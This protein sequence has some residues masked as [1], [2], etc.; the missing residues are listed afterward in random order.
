MTLAVPSPTLVTSVTRVTPGQPPW[1]PTLPTPWG[2]PTQVGKAQKVE[3]LRFPE[4]VLSTVLR[5]ETAEL[6]QTGLVRMQLQIEL[7]EPFT[8]LAQELSR[9]IEVL[10]PDHEVVGEPGDDHVAPSG[11]IPPMPDPQVE[12]VMKVHV[13]EQR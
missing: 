8:K 11:P 6:D 10:K 9:I 2:H 13:S 3:R 12:N 5:R 4:P 7:R 1:L